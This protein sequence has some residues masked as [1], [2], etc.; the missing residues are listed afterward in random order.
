M[1]DSNWIITLNRLKLNGDV[2]AVLDEIAGKCTQPPIGP[3]TRQL[4][5]AW[6]SHGGNLSGGKFR[7]GECQGFN[8]GLSRDEPFL[9]V[10]L[11]RGDRPRQVIKDLVETDPVATRPIFEKL[12]RLSRDADAQ[13][14][15]LKNAAM[16]TQ[17]KIMMAEVY[18]YSMSLL[19]LIPA[20]F[21]A[22]E[23]TLDKPT[24]P[25]RNHTSISEPS[26][27][28]IRNKIN[29]ESSWSSVDILHAV[30]LLHAKA[31]AE[32]DTVTRNRKSWLKLEAELFGDPK[33]FMRRKRNHGLGFSA[34]LMDGPEVNY[35][36]IAGLPCN[37]T[38]HDAVWGESNWQSLLDSCDE[39]LLY[40]TGTIDEIPGRSDVY[41]WISVDNPRRFARQLRELIISMACHAVPE[42]TA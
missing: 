41:Y 6:A 20:Q 4:L 36:D 3:V 1:I 32:E 16:P 13:L 19:E 42:S 34:S 33:R 40:E 38:L 27:D 24:I 17:S 23:L 15:N 7:T 12:Y 14:K 28:E 26:H 37:D 5:V 2:K 8:L 21:R 39:A 18:K 22:I 9:S 10:V 29:A 35:F 31:S 25:D 11:G 30:H